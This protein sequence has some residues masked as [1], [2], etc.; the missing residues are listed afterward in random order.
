MTFTFDV[1]DMHMMH[2]KFDDN[3]IKFYVLYEYSLCIFFFVTRLQRKI[4]WTNKMYN[5][6]NL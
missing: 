4:K 6:S 1:F 5:A 3:K 2:F